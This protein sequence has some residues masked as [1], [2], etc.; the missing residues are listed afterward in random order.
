M[1]VRD[2]MSRDPITCRSVA[3][4]RNPLE[5][6]AG[7]C[8]TPA[9]ITVRSE[10]DPEDCEHRMEEHQVRRIMVVDEQ[11]CCGAIVS[12][13]DIAG[14]SRSAPWPRSS[15]RSPGRWRRLRPCSDRAATEVIVPVAG[16]RHARSGSSGDGHPPD[17]WTDPRGR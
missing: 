10:T 1:K 5:M 6:T 15:G 11:G 3:M 2:F 12:Q 13:A 14:G 9:A 16:I 7:D 17:P 4:R 8:M